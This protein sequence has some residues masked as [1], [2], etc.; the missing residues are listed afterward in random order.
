MEQGFYRDRLSSL[1]VEAVVP[2]EVDRTRIQ[3][4]IYEELVRGIINPQ[5]R[6]A[7]LQIVGAERAAG[8]DG[9]IL[10]CTELGMLVNEGDIR[11]PTFNSLELHARAGLEF[12]LG[13]S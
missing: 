4:M 2:G 3:R 9:V 1:G 13:D 6:A 7:L 10:G 5:S 8:A 11:V 12:A